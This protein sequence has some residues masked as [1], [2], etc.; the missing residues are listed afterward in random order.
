MNMTANHSTAATDPGNLAGYID[1]TLLK[2]DA[3]PSE[4]IKICRE[5]EQYGFMAV[6]IQPCWLKMA[7]S[8]LSNSNVLVATVIGFPMGMNTSLTKQREAEEAAA[9]GAEELDMV[10]NVAFLKSGEFAKVLQDIKGVVNAAP[11]ITVKVIIE[12]CLLTDPE[13]I[14][15]CGLA[16][17]AGAAFVKTSTGLAG[18]GATVNDVRLMRSSVGPSFGVK[19]SGGIRTREDAVS[20]IKAGANRIGTSA[21]VQIV[22]GKG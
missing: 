10:I 3:K 14:S 16:I 6:C 11:E 7:V 15:A 5:A 18:G 21:G 9:L 2:S 17:D 22:S 4:I 1:H 19:A 13:K 8:E 12:T 20:M